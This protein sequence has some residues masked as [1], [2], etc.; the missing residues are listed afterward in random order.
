MTAA[1]A[2]P[3]AELPFWDIRPHPTLPTLEV[4]CMD[5]PAEPAD[6]AA[7][8]AIIRALVVTAAEAVRRGDPGPRL[9]GELLRSAYW[10]ATRDGWTGRGMDV[11][12]GEVLA[13]PVRGARLLE[14]IGAALRAHGD[15]DTATAFVQRLGRRGSGA[16]RQRAAARLPGGLAAV[17][18]DLTAPI[19]PAGERTAA[20][21]EGA[22]EFT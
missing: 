9:C 16:H 11:L 8:A 14:H 7:L 2:M 4:R 3:F 12:T 17:V 13:A 22:A 6:S 1:G 19:P 10:Y 18:D 15:A 5:V 20:G 21:P